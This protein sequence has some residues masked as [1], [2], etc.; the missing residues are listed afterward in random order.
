MKERIIIE[1]QVN[2]KEKQKIIDCLLKNK[3]KH[4]FYTFE[5]GT[6][7]QKEED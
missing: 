6:L 1:V 2:D 5:I 3:I 4:N 7:G